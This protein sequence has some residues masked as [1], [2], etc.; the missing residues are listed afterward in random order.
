MSRGCRGPRRWAVRISCL[1]RFVKIDNAPPARPRRSR[2]RRRSPGLRSA[3]EPAKRSTR[4]CRMI[5]RPPLRFCRRAKSRSLWPSTPKRFGCSAAASPAT[6]WQSAN[7]L[8]AVKARAAGAASRPC[9]RT[10]AV[11]SV[12]PNGRDA[13]IPAVGRTAIEP[14]EPTPKRP[15]VGTRHMSRCGRAGGGVDRSAHS[16]VAC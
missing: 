1:A 6:S 3:R 4:R 7:R 9:A 10:D 14:P 5:Y 2:A 11:R 8:I 15:I 13:P 12:M 16:C